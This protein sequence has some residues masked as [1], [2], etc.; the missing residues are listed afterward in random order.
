MIVDI[1]VD[2]MTRYTIQLQCE[3]SSIALHVKIVGNR[4]KASGGASALIGSDVIVVQQMVDL[5]LVHVMFEGATKQRLDELGLRIQE[6]KHRCNHEIELVCS[7]AHHEADPRI[8]TTGGESIRRIH[9][10]PVR[11]WRGDTLYVN[12]H[13]GVRKDVAMAEE[14]LVAVAESDRLHGTHTR[15]PVGRIR[16]TQRRGEL[17]SSQ[18]SVRLRGVQHRDGGGLQDHRIEETLAV[19]HARLHHGGVGGQPQCTHTASTLTEQ[20]HSTRITTEG[21]NV[22]LHP[23]QGQQLVAETKVGVGQLWDG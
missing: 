17:G 15:K 3:V 7:G 22:T 11:M 14:V 19:G 20:R 9:P 23:A 6:R 4:S 10:G 21:A 1:F 2:R 8:Q 18:V 12:R 5:L 13:T 16:A